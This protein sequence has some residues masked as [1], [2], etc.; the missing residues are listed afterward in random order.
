MNKKTE[1]KTAKKLPKKITRQDAENALMEVID[2][3][4]GINIVDLGLVY[5]LVIR[6]N[7]ITLKMT[8]TFPGC[9][10]AGPI[11]RQAQDVLEK[12][13]NVK[14]VKVFLVWDPP[15]TPD[16][17]KESAKDELGLS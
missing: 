5:K 10:L 3:E 12:I 1:K 14:T 9:P 8:L 15:W 17:V 2:P 13:P 7:S 4:L 6:D 16:M 11:T